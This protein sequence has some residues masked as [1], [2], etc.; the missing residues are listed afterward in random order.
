MYL[1][2]RSEQPCARKS[3]NSM[4]TKMVPK[5]SIG[6]SISGIVVAQ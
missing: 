1:I 6:N 3:A 2:M 4:C 5:G